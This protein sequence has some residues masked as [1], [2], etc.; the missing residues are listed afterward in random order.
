MCSTNAYHQFEFQALV[1]KVMPPHIWGAI[2]VFGW[3]EI[4]LE[5]RVWL[6]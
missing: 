3:Y 2:V 6:N 4:L 1:W 5:R